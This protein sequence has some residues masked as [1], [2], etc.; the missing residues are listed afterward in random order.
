MVCTHLMNNRID[1]LEVVEEPLDL[2]S[3][4]ARL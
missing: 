2:V 4:E 3:S 1:I